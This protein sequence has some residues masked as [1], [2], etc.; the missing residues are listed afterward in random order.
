MYQQQKV[1]ELSKRFPL[2]RRK[3]KKKRLH[4]TSDTTEHKTTNR[5][6]NLGVHITANCLEK[7]D[8]IAIRVH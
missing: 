4:I 1:I 5:W 6:I 8:H 2:G 7:S 3:N